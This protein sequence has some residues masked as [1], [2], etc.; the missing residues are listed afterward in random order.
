M[1]IGGVTTSYPRTPGEAAGSFVAAHVAALRALGHAVEVIGA[2]TIESEL[3]YGAGAPDELER[4]RLRSSLAAA[5]F[6]A[7]LAI[8]VARRARHWDQIVAHW[9]APSALAAVPS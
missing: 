6:S 1:G 9:L 3:F 7:R 5:R 8:A 2:H 4:N